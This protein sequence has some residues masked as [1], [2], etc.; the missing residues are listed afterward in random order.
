MA[1]KTAEN[2]EALLPNVYFD[3]RFDIEAVKL[4]PGQYFVAKTHKLLVTVAASTTVVCL[5]DRYRHIGGMTNFM[6]AD[7]GRDHDN[8]ASAAARSGTQVMDLLLAKLAVAGARDTYAIEAKIFGGGK[9][10]GPD[11]GN[12]AR[13]TEFLIKYLT[14]RKIR[15]AAQSLRGDFARKVYFFPHTGRLLVRKIRKANNN[16]IFDREREYR[17]WLNEQFPSGQ[18]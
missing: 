14:A 11:L 3:E 4:T 18:G 6:L 9:L 17:R 8:P 12:G 10:G 5:R 15:I 16:T 1:A 7:F 2:T 13:N